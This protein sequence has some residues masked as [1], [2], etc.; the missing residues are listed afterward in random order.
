[1]PRRPRRRLPTRLRHLA[2]TRPRTRR[3]P[4]VILRGRPTHPVIARSRPRQS[5][6][7][8][9]R[10]TSRQVRHRR[11]C[12]YVRSRRSRSVRPVGYS[13]PVRYLVSR[14]DQEVVGRVGTKT[15]HNE[16][17]RMPRR[18]RRRLP[19]RL[20]HLAP[21]R[22]RTRR[23][24]NVILRGRPTHPVIARSRPRQSQTRRRRRTSRQVR[25]RRRC[26]YVGRAFGRH[27][28]AAAPTIG[29]DAD[30][31]VLCLSWRDIAPNDSH[32]HDVGFATTAA[33]CRRTG[34]PVVA[35]TD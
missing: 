26:R 5:Q 31:A 14:L 21:T 7:R 13:G 32:R 16:T 28:D 9:R 3:I 8:R 19:T 29:A 22:P 20:R 12:R 30:R 4:N 10:R 33:A 24:P 35:L 18:P 25:H 15:R 23:I 17:L 11:R 27:V 34:D 1:M 6:T 2:P